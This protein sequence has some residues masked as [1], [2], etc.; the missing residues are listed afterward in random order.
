MNTNTGIRFNRS[1]SHF[2]VRWKEFLSMPTNFTRRQFLRSSLLLGAAVGLNIPAIGQMQDATPE[3]DT[4]MNLELTGSVRRIHDPVIIKAEDTYY[5]F[6]TGR[7]ISARQSP[8]LIDWEI[9][10]PQSVFG[11]PPAWAQEMIPGQMDIWA[12]DI[13]YYN[14][15]YHLYYSV[16]T[17]G[18]NRSVIGLATNTTLDFEDEAFEWV[19]QGLVIESTGV[20]NYNCIDPNLIID[21]D[22]V[23][24]LV[25]GS[26]WSGIKMRRLDYA[27]G[28][29]ST[30]DTTL[31]ALSERSIN[32]GSV[33]AP[34]IISREGFYY[35]F[36]SFDFCC[37]G[38]DSTYHVMVGRSETITGPYV[39]REGVE[40]LDGGGT[41]VTFPTERWRGPGHN[42]ILRDNDVD[43]IVY[44][45]YDAEAE[46]TPT[47][48]ID[49][50]VWDD[51]G[52]PAILGAG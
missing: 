8:D 4:P 12:P 44:H 41:Q 47:L 33:E 17:F 22:G 11:S 9:P 7:G 2:I 13:S 42:A 23:P 27:T 30:E 40:M 3:G 16:S 24:W 25:F 49:P 48:R 43:Y 26:F 5:L 15:K 39:D 18:S 1:N 38:V 52:W 21:N 32:S 14:D 36:V 45:S 50:L 29:L 34:F 31:Y 10:F 28:K 35:L 37:R 51:E 46:G 20:E 19:D 6:C